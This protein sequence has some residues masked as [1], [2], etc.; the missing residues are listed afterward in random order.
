[1]SSSLVNNKAQAKANKRKF[2]VRLKE[3]NVHYRNNNTNECFSHHGQL[4]LRWY[5]Y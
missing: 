2:P 4:S 5:N 1:M 3:K